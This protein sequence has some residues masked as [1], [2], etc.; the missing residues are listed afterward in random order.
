VGVA[1]TRRLNKETAMNARKLAL[2]VFASLT[3]VGMLSS[4]SGCVVYGRPAPARYYYW[5]R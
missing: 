1:E 5:H 4:L 2:K 3:L